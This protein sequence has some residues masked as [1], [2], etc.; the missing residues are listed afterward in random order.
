MIRLT[1]PR[2]NYSLQN[3]KLINH[4]SIPEGN[5]NGVPVIQLYQNLQST[6]NSKLTIQNSPIKNQYF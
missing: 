6:E 3:S 5:T 2:E 1:I 4:K